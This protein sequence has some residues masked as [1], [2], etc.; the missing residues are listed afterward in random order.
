MLDSSAPDAPPVSPRAHVP[1][2]TFTAAEV[3][4]V[5]HV[6]PILPTTAGTGSGTGTGTDVTSGTGVG[7]TMNPDSDTMKDMTT[8]D[9]GG[10]GTGVYMR[11]TIR[12]CSMDR[13][14]L[15]SRC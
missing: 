4:E 8:E 1:P 12:Q 13:V 6:T 10:K 15:G 7:T 3:P 9:E 11:R 2:G 5:L 14:C